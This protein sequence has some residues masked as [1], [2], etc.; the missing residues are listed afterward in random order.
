[1]DWNDFYKAIKEERY[2]SVY[3][4]AGPEELTKREALEAL[5]RAILPP[6]L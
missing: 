1:M 2:Q 3:L 4:F 5:R 6:G